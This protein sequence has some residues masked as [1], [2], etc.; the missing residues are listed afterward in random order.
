MKLAPEFYA[1]DG[2]PIRLE[3][4]DDTY[5]AYVELR[6]E[7]D[8]RLNHARTPVQAE[9]ALKLLLYVQ[10]RAQREQCYTV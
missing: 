6:E 8:D 7:A 10:H 4:I 5:A 2:A 9:K 1:A 3:F